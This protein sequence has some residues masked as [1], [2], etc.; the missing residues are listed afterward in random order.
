MFMGTAK[1]A[2]V[3]KSHKRKEYVMI[4]KAIAS[5]RHARTRSS[6][7]TKSASC[8]VLLDIVKEE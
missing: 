1:Q 7:Y 3:E 4:T 8:E 6:T 5:I 2:V